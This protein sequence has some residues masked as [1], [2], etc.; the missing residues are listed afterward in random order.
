MGFKKNTGSS[1]WLPLGSY[2]PQTGTGKMDHCL[3]AQGKRGHWPE[4]SQSQQCYHECQNL[5]AMA[6]FPRKTLGCHL[7]RQICQSQTSGGAHQI[8]TQRQRIANM[9]HGQATLPLDS[10]AQFLGSKNWKNNTILDGCLVP[11]ATTKLH[12]KSTSKL[13]RRGTTIGKDL[14][15]QD[16]GDRARLQEMETR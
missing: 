12:S 5:V 2:K 10:A 4:G 1:A 13:H 16:S 3:H 6:L 11:N 14:E 8:Y 9:E 15:T 7:D